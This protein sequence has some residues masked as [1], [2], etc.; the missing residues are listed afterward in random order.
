MVTSKVLD[1]P[2]SGSDSAQVFH[3]Y[4]ISS[5]SGIIRCH[6]RASVVLHLG[7]QYVCQQHFVVFSSIGSMAKKAYTAYEP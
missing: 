1:N 3:T 2:L 5:P 6:L 7:G 4:L